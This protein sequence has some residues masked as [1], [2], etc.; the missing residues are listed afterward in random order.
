VSQ[1]ALEAV[2]GRAVIDEEFRLRLFADPEAA[3][4]G[5]ALTEGEVAALKR[6]D[7]ESLEACGSRL[8]WCLL[9]EL[10]T[11]EPKAPE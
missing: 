3:L 1:Q 8:A 5:Y 9:Q 6:V 11:P 2:I 7:A 10:M 4:D